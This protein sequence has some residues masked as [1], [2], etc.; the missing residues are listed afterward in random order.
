MKIHE[1]FHVKGI[2]H[3]DERNKMKVYTQIYLVYKY[4]FQVCRTLFH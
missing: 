2:F 1:N 4:I 3:N